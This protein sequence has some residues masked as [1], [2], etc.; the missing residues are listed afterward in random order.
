[1][2]SYLCVY[3][4]YICRPIA[5]SV[6]NEEYE[7]ETVP[8]FYNILYSITTES[9]IPVFDSLVESIRMGESIRIRVDRVKG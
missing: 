1:M 2:P 4:K 9:K 7:T 6:Q 3:S 8:R 5:C